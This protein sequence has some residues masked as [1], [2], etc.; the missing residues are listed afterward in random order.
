MNQRDWHNLVS[1]RRAGLAA[2]F[3]RLLLGIAACTYSLVIR[4]RNLLYSKGWLKA[5][6]TN[7][8][9]ISIGNITAGGTG[10]TPLVIWLCNQLSQNYKCAILTRG[11]RGTENSK[12][13]TQNFFDEPAILAESCP[14]AKVIVNPDRVAGAAEAVGRFGTKVLIMDDGFQHRRLARDLDIIAIDA[15][16]PFGYGRILPAGLLR[17]PVAA[18]K[19]A[20]AVVITRSDQA[21]EAQLT[22][23][24]H[25]I[26]HIK[27]DMII[28]TSIHAPVCAESADAGQI[29]LEELK[30]K[31]IFAFCGIGNPD[32]FLNTIKN[33][34]ANLLGSKIFDDH[35]HY[36]DDC[37]AQVCEQAERIEADLVLTTQKDWTKI[38]PLLSAEK[39]PPFAYLAIEIRFSA[40]EDKLR[41][42]IED[43]LAGKISQQ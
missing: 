5:H 27:A 21:A 35:H 26:R 23:L 38:A 9:V 36:T 34:G 1:G 17:E 33:L 43:T 11:Y 25:K 10:K 3:L 18:L 22:R 14:D 20:D 2:A 16:R 19:R 40:G 12:L 24:E 15:T 32:A 7:A 6:R 13:K 4:L 41:R 28:A 31:K 39:R 29:S 30:A 8:A 37:L 42:L